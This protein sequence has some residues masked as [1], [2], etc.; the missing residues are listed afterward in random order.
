MT[1]YTLRFSE[2]GHGVD[3]RLEFKAEDLTA[4]LIIAHREAAR[5]SA[6]LWAGAKKLCTIR[7]PA[8]PAATLNQYA[9]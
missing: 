1:I 2:D 8:E 6:E 9:F 7:K 4:A 3:R 5:R